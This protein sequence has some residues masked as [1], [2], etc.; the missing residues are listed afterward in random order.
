MKTRKRSHSKGKVLKRLP[1]RRNDDLQT[2]PCYLETGVLTYYYK[3]SLKL[4]ERPLWLILVS[5][6]V[7]SEAY[8]ELDRVV[9][10]FSR[11]E[12]I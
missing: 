5:K 4:V 11:Y 2:A 9:V 6:T 7:C 3:I 12:P 1:G 10:L 8:R